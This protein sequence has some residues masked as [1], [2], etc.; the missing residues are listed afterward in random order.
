M[1]LHEFFD[2]PEKWTQNGYARN[3][4]RDVVRPD[5]ADAIQW[6]VLGAMAKCQIPDDEETK[7]RTHL[8]ENH[9]SGRIASW[10]DDPNLTF[11]Q[12]RATLLLLDI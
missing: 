4:K 10:N 8:R 6:C 11:E 5:A 7:L 2:S 9:D 12:M 3:K 1:K